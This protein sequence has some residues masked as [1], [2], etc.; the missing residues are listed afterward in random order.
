LFAIFVSPLSASSAYA[1]FYGYLAA[2]PA[3]FCQPQAK[4][5]R[6]GEN[7][8]PVFSGPLFILHEIQD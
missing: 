6:A 7:Q 8:N 5:R 3:A 1:D 4:G 2:G